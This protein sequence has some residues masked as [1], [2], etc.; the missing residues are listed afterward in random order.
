MIYKAAIDLAVENRK[1]QTIIDLDT[2]LIGFTE[3]LKGL[4]TE[5]YFSESPIEFGKALIKKLEPLFAEKCQ[6]NFKV[7]RKHKK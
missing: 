6:L 2:G 4:T 3:S 5:F 1:V 7:S